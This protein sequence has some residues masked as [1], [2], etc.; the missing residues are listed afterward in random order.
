MTATAPFGERF[1]YGLYPV[2]FHGAKGKTI[3]HA[4]GL[5]PRGI[6][7]L[8]LRQKPLLFLVLFHAKDAGWT[9]PVF[10]GDRGVGH[11]LS[12]YFILP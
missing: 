2:A 10:P 12:R 7:F 8:H 5:D 11:G 4:D 6:I 3:R 1:F 9:F